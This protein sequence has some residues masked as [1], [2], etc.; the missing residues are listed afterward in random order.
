MSCSTKFRIYDI[1]A[2]SDIR[3]VF[4]GTVLEDLELLG[5]TKSDSLL[6]H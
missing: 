2:T 6:L 5:L 3:P 4:T 1:S